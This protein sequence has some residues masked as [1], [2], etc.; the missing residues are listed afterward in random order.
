MADIDTLKIEQFNWTLESILLRMVHFSYRIYLS[1]NVV[2]KT[3]VHITT[4]GIK[5]TM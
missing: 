1:R 5:V 4:Y 3:A 2:F